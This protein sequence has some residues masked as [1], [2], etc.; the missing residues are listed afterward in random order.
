[1]KSFNT[2]PI[3]VLFFTMLQLVSIANCQCLVDNCKTCPNTTELTCTA[4]NSGWYLR[5][6]SGGDKEYNACWRLW[7]LIVGIIGAALSYCLCGLCCYLCRR[8]GLQDRTKSRIRRRTEAPLETETQPIKQNSPRQPVQNQVISEASQT[9]TPV[10]V[11]R[12]PVRRTLPTVYRTSPQPVRTVQP[13]V[14]VTPNPPPRSPPVIR[15]TQPVYRPVQ[16]PVYRPQQQPVR[17]LS[18]QRAQPQ[19]RPV[20]RRIAQSPT[21]SAQPRYYPAS[22]RR[23]VSPQPQIQQS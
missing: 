14:Y 3:C 8:K 18:P 4:C 22:P 19:T 17:Y 9:N 1:M 23:V 20:V 11:T 12:T 2:I 6:F 5:T 21:T 16:Q 10:P 15:Q 13:V 7:K